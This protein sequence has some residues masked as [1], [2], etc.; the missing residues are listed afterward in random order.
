M[1]KEKKIFGM[2]VAV[3]LLIIIF[4]ENE[5]TRQILAA[6]GLSLKDTC[7]A[8]EG[9]IHNQETIRFGSQEVQSSEL[10]DWGR[11]ACRERVITPVWIYSSAVHCH[12]DFFHHMT[13]FS[14]LD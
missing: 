1:Q 4:S 5:E 11:E 2:I 14:V 6:W 12:H 8:L 7:I 13:F 9:R 10:A 3:L